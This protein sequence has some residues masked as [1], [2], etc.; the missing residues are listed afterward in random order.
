[1]LQQFGLVIFYR[2]FFFLGGGWCLKNSR[3][4]KIHLG[5][6]PDA[7]CWSDFRARADEAA[8]GLDFQT[9]IKRDT[10][11]LGGSCLGFCSNPEVFLC[12]FC[13]NRYESWAFFLSVIDGWN[14]QP[15]IGGVTI[16]NLYVSLHT[17]NAL[18][19]RKLL[20]CGARLQQ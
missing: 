15:G 14:T 19:L 12:V 3:L 9:I 2:P 16:I 7:D 8:E 6:C 11:G 20:G 5:G 1:M 13:C 10:P 4:W 18:I 17:A